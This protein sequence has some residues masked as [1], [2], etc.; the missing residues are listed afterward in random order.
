MSRFE[1]QISGKLKVAIMLGMV[2]K[3]YQDLVMQKGL[4]QV[5]KGDGDKMWKVTRDFVLKVAKEKAQQNKPV[6]MEV[7]QVRD[8]AQRGAT[9]D[10]TAQLGD[11]IMCP[12]PILL[13]LHCDLSC[14]ETC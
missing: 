2:G 6:P 9:G 8:S 5:A 13:K 1:E 12:R 3:D 10:G 11:E 14:R 7:G 4:L